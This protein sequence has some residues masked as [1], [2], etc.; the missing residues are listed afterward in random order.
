MYPAMKVFYCTLVVLILNGCKTASETGITLLIK[1]DSGTLRLVGYVDSVEN[2]IPTI[3]KWFAFEEEIAQE[4]QFLKDLGLDPQLYNKLAVTMDQLPKIHEPFDMLMIDQ[5]FFNKNKIHLDGPWFP[6]NL[7]ELN[8]VT[9]L[10]S[11]KFNKQLKM[12]AYFPQQTK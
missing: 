2:S 9:T 7:D 11:Q 6:K 1:I 3:V 12:H 4:R 8:K 5:H 10:L